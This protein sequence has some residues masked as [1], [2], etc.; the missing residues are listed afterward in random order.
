MKAK[1][2]I[3]ILKRLELYFLTGVPDSG[4]RNFLIYIEG[5]PEELKH[6]RAVN[7]GQAIAFA[8]GYHLATGMV[9][10]V[11]MQN[12]GL[13]NAINPLT[14][15]A[16]KEV[17]GIPA[18]LFIAW[19]GRP[20]EPDEPQ[21]KKMGRIMLDF[22][23]TLE[24]PFAIANKEK[25][26]AEEQLKSLKEQ[27]LKSKHPVAF[28]FPK[29]VIDEEKTDKNS[30]GTKREEILEILLDK[31]GKKPVIGTTGYASREIFEIR[32]RKKQGH[33]MDFLCVGSMGHA[34]SI[35]LAI[36]KNSKTGVYVIDGDGALCMHMGAAASIGFYAPDNLCHIVIDN[37]AHESTGG[38]PTISRTIDWKK[39]FLSLGYKTV[40]VINGVEKVKAI[41]L[42]SLTHPSAIVIKLS[43][44]ARKNLGRP[45]TAPAENKTAFMN[46]LKELQ[47]EQR[48]ET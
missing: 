39:F 38:Q 13:G 41:D 40:K 10:I 14:S 18:I 28:V 45:T 17:Y 9:P 2:L 22:L 23:K 44:G 27:T 47:H 8:A 26:T 24:I 30:E 7:E 29:G 5:H 4:L 33:D 42:S 35:A 43:Q 12:S 21:H 31:I 1:E 11:Y 46:F 36:A 20:N 15:L 3:E 32:E 25:K 37:G 16:D 48:R 6:M 19:R 34:S